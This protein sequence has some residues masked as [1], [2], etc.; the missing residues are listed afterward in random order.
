MMRPIQIKKR[1]APAS[2]RMIIIWPVNKALAQLEEPGFVTLR[3]VYD[4]TD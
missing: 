1:M 2:T 4:F 3:A